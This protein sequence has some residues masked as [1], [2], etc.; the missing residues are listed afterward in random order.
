[1]LLRGLV[2]VRTNPGRKETVQLYYANNIANKQ[3]KDNIFNDFLI[4][5]TISSEHF[6]LNYQ[7]LLKL[8]PGSATT[9]WNMTLSCIYLIL[10]LDH[11]KYFLTRLQN[12]R[13][14]CTLIEKNV[15]RL[16]IQ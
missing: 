2:L 16:K 10:K 14:K 11:R 5:T 4:Y 15:E 6:V 7:P 12:V 1:M 9:D 8:Q 3:H 13:M